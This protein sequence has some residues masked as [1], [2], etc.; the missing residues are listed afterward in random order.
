MSPGTETGAASP[1]MEVAGNPV[2]IDDTL[3]KKIVNDATAFL[4]SYASKRNR[5]VDLAATAVTDA[6]A[7]SDKEALDGKLID[8]VAA[9]QDELLAKLDGR[10]ITRFDGSTTQLALAHPVLT[11]REMT[12]REKFLSR[13]VQPDVFFILLIVGILGLYT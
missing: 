4:R 9:S 7:F 3:R 11:A 12:P 5:N 10:T 13:I 6:K 2:Q 8:I 1:L